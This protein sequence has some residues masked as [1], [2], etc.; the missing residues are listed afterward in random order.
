MALDRLATFTWQIPTAG[1]QWVDAHR[2]DQEP[3]TRWLTVGASEDQPRTGRWDQPLEQYPALLRT[4]ADTPLTEEDMLRFA[5]THGALGFR[6]RILVPVGGS[7]PERR[8]LGDPFE[9]WCDHIRHLRLAL[10]LRD[11]IATRDMRTLKARL[12]IHAQQGGAWI[13]Y[14]HRGKPFEVWYTALEGDRS[15]MPVDA[16]LVPYLQGKGNGRV[17]I[18]RA[19]L[20]FVQTLV[21]GPLGEWDNPQVLYSPAEDR[22]VQQIVPANLVG[23]LWLQYAQSLTSHTSYRRCQEC[24]T[25]FAVSP[26]KNRT[27]RL[28]CDNPCRSRAYRGRQAKARQLAAQGISLDAI[29]EE[30]KTDAKTAEKWVVQRRAGAR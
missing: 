19:A 30:L 17:K 9:W 16:G 4:F 2:P 25:W 26:D 22:L 28:F 7:A 23:A 20:F 10:Q 13:E 1:Y 11:A 6:E 29:A 24:G 21:N 15:T 27:D 3:L 14:R 18:L 5:N 12:T 8:A